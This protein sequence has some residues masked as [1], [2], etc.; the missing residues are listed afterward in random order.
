MVDAG[1]VLVELDPANYRAK[2]DA[3][4]AD[5][6]AARASAVG[7][8]AALALTEKTAPANVAQA[9]GG[10][11]A[12][13]SSVASAQAPSWRPR[14]I[15]A[16][17]ESRKTLA[18]LNLER[19]RALLDQKAVAQVDLDSRQTDFDNASA[20]LDQARA[21]RVSAEASLAG[22]GGGVVLAQGRLRA[23]APPPSRWTQ[24]ARRWALGGGA[25]EQ[26][27]A[28][29]AQASSIGATPR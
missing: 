21:R 10:V 5:V 25:G 14:R 20:Q 27:V 4:R 2:V 15:F 22:S 23:A 19:S 26:T 29:L 28:A 8:R 9:K 16:A 1:D 24:P 12:A 17:A 6:A 7:A 18:A 11:T 13:S 3:A